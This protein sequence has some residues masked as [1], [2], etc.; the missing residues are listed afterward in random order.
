M[1]ML[2]R[3]RKS[4]GSRKRRYLH[5]FYSEKTMLKRKR[6]KNDIYFLSFCL[7]FST[8]N[9]FIPANFCL[10]K[11]YTHKPVFFTSYK[12]INIHIFEKHI[13]I[14]KKQLLVI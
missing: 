5:N 2:V 8:I 14:S 10:L 11:I 13:Y 3:V 9:A 4:E 12:Y 7:K 6:S 1:K